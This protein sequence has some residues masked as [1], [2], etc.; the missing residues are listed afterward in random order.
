MA[1]K[2]DRNH[3]PS[4]ER[5]A[6]DDRLTARYSANLEVNNNTIASTL[7]T[8]RGFIR[9]GFKSCLGLLLLFSRVHQP[10]VQMNCDRCQ[11][12]PAIVLIIIV[13]IIYNP[14]QRRHFLNQVFLVCL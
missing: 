14:D 8:N 4:R 11:D 12:H 6:A 5:G 9:V 3:S 13:I 7:S 2:V 1:L 10:S